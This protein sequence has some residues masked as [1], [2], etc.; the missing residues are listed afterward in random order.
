VDTPLVES[1]LDEGETGVDVDITELSLTRDLQ[2]IFDTNLTNYTN[3]ALAVFDESNIFQELRHNIDT[4]AFTCMRDVFN[5][6]TPKHQ[7][8]VEAFPSNITIQK[9]ND[10]LVEN[11]SAS[12]S[13]VKK[14]LQADFQQLKISEGQVQNCIDG[15]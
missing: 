9:Y 6:Y 7:D 2:S 13:R 4:D 11:L 3:S 1:I 10:C 14:Q 5:N 8:L 12:I 15:A